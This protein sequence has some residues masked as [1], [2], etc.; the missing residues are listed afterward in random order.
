MKVKHRNKK[1]LKSNDL[2][3]NLLVISLEVLRLGLEAS[4]EGAAVGVRAVDE[5]QLAV[6]EPLEQLHPH[7]SLVGVGRD[8]AQ[9]RD[10]DV[11]EGKDCNKL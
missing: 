10:V 1:S 8:C 11:L 7:V 5:D 2:H 3:L 9:E 4:E 6:L